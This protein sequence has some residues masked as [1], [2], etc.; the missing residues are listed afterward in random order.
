M[1]EFLIWGTTANKDLENILSCNVSNLKIG[2]CKYGFICNHKGGVNDDQIIYKISDT[3]F[4]M[5]VNASTQLSDF[6][7]INSHLSSNTFIKNISEETGKID[8]QGPLSVKIISKILKNPINDLKYYHWQHNYYKNKKIIVSRTGYTGEIG[9]EI[10]F[11]DSKHTIDFWNDCLSLGAKPAGLGARDILRLE[12]G[13]PLYGHELNENQN[14]AESGYSNAIARNK[15]FIGS[16]VILNPSNIHN[17]L[18]G[19]KLNSRRTARNGDLIYDE[20]G[21]NIGRITSGS[22]SPSLGCSIA[23][24]YIDKNKFITGTQV[25]IKTCANVEINGI[26]VDLPFYKNGTLRKNLQELL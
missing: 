5:V 20:K 23:L 3:E 22:Y 21:Q 26:I 16:N 1:G 6:E 14:A 8:L 25:I 10:Y 9:F 12:I 13:Y 2:Q 7:W 18:C 17:L 24:G 15:Q 11:D 19:I 4:F